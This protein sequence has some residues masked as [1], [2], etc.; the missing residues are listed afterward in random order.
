MNKSEHKLLHN[1]KL[2]NRL[3]PNICFHWNWKTLWSQLSSNTPDPHWR[4]HA[5]MT[6]FMAS[7]YCITS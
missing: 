1:Y 5:I 4:K 2:D 7:L 6:H 3:F